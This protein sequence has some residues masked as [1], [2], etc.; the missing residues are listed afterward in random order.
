MQALKVLVLGF[1]FG[2]ILRY[3]RL[4]RYDTISGLATLEDLTV[5]K[6]LAVAIGVGILLVHGEVALGWASFHI[7][8]LVVGGIALGGLL[9]GAGM[10][11]LGYCPGTLA[12][13]LGEGSVD[14][15]AGVLG[16]LL[17]GWVFTLLWPSL[18]PILG[19]SLG[20]PALA[21]GMAAA[22]I[23]VAI[24]GV[25]AAGF[26]WLAYGLHRWRPEPRRPWLVAGL[27]L[28]LL[29]AGVFLKVAENRPIGA[30]TAYPYL[31]DRLTGTTQHP[32]FQRIATSG[33]WEVLFL[34]G[35]ALAGLA[36]ALAQGRFR[37]VV[38]HERWRH[39]RGAS[40]GGRLAWA[41]V[42]GFVLIFGARM[43]GGCTSGHI[44]SGG[45]QLAVSS[46]LFMAFVALG[47]L[48][49]G[50]LF[51]RETNDRIR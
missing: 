46:L 24:V 51:Y 47:F 42:G 9:F 29:D 44:L 6:A 30:S 41:L 40:V 3:A 38:V 32:Y 14:A 31:A 5:A 39:Y 2:T 28:A 8:P 33:S 45:M 22:P 19:P 35:A 27:L 50:R 43:A 17:G 49:T 12:V 1:L 25:S 37:L 48:G 13:S 26:L 7:K 21:T 10:A 15:L 20:K 4:N 11:I 36:F 18:I 16:G 34:L 23:R